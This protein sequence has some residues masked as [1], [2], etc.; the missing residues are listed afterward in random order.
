MPGRKLTIRVSGMLAGDPGQGGA[1]WAVLQYL[2]GF[3]RLGHDVYFVEP[4]DPSKLGN[5][6]PVA[7]AAASQS[8]EPSASAVY[9]NELTQM[10]GLAG[11]CA[12]LGKGTHQTVGLTYGELV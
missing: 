8:L 12:L 2:L 1:S 5:V 7:D 4:V 6:E 11:C 10:F 3:R 9:F